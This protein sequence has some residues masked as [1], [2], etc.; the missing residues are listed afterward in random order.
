MRGPRQADRR[1][2]EDDLRNTTGPR[3]MLAVLV[4]D[5]Y[6]MGVVR[7]LDQRL[8]ECE[9]LSGPTAG[10]RTIGGWVSAELARRF[11]SEP[12]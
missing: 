1:L 6:A 2:G 9:L 5:V 11:I 7:D 12:E 3:V 4:H 10:T 8:S